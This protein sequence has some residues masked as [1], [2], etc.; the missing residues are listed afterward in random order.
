MNA[1]ARVLG[2]TSKVNCEIVIQYACEDT[3]DPQVDSFW[4]FTDTKNN[5]DN[6]SSSDNLLIVHT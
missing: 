2:Q 6:V 4:P 1:H 3:L 5:A